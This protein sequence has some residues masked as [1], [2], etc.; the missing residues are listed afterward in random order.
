MINLL[1]N[2]IKYSPEKKIIR[3]S[4]MIENEYAI[5]KIEDEGIGISQE[6]IKK[7]FQAFCQDEEF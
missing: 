1:S 5:V 3:V 7:H 2:A 4:S 6:D